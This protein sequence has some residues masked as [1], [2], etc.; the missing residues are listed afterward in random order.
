MLSE[1]LDPA[2][3][4]RKGLTAKNM[5][6]KYESTIT[7]HATVVTNDKQT[8][9]KLHAPNLSTLKLEN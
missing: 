2:L 5:D 3:H 9:A 6:M 7:Y 1:D 8:W 4:Q